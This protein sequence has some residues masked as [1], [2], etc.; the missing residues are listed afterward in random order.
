MGPIPLVCQCFTD[1]VEQD[2]TPRIRRCA[3]EA[4]QAGV[5]AEDLVVAIREGWRGLPEQL[6]WAP[7]H[8]AALTNLINAAL[9]T[10]DGQ[11]FSP[12][13]DR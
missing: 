8:Q 3:M 7:G 5:S 11:A 6:R 9:E 10:Y 13:A 2:V 12:P 4:R 1:G